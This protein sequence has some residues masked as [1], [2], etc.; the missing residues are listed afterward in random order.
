MPELPLVAPADGETR[1]REK[2]DSI[3]KEIPERK[4]S[5]YEG[6]RKER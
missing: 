6:E 2:R 3:M 4:N 1:E 5:K